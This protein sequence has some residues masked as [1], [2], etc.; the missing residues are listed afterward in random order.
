M[1][2]LQVDAFKD[3]YRVITYDIRGHGNSE[4]GNEDFSI[5]LFVSDLIGLM[6]SLKIDKAIVCGLSMGGY[7]ALNAAGKYSKR[8]DALVL[9]DTQC[10]ADTP[11]TKE[12]RMMAIESIRKNGVEKYAEESIKNLFASETFSTRISTVADVR[13]M[14]EKTTEQSLCNTLLALSVRNETCSILPEIEIP[15]LIMVGKEDKL[16][17]PAAATFMH[18][19]IKGSLLK[20][21]DHAGHLSNMQNPVEFNLQLKE[22]LVSVNVNS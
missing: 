6:D 22:F 11:E 12:K 5:D 19:K 16:T 20:I 15:V 1:W 13:K 17:P 2:D 14:I 4:P 8:F 10:I 3:N 18:K 21:L 9:A 7:I